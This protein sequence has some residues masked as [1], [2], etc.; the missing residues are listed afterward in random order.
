MRLSC[1]ITPLL[2]VVALIAAASTFAAPVRA[3]ADDCLPPLIFSPITPDNAAALAPVA[4]IGRGYHSAILWEDDGFRVRSEAGW[5]RYSLDLSGELCR[6]AAPDTLPVTPDSAPDAVWNRIP[7]DEQPFSRVLGVSPSGETWLIQVSIFASERSRTEV[8]NGDGSLRMTLLDAQAAAAA[9]SADESQ[10]ALLYPDGAITIMDASSGAGLAFRDGLPG[11]AA[12]M[13]ISPDG[14]AVMIGDA[15]GVR[16]WDA[17]TNMLIVS[18]PGS[19]GAVYLPDGASVAM[20][21]DEALAFFNISD[22]AEASSFPSEFQAFDTSIAISPDGRHIGIAHVLHGWSVYDAEAGLLFSD[23][24]LSE[25]YESDNDIALSDTHVAVAHVPAPDM[26]SLVV[27]RLADRALALE[28]LTAPITPLTFAP[29]GALLY[30][31]PDSTLEIY[32]LNA[33]AV[34]QTFAL[35]GTDVRDAQFSP[36]GRLLAGVGGGSLRVWDVASG[37]L[38][39]QAANEDGTLLFSPDG[40]YIVT[41][42]WHCY[43]CGSDESSQLSAARVWGIPAA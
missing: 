30:A 37:A 43:I 12:P 28:R 17:A 42:D 25:I 4:H 5:W 9:F 23:Y 15:Q 21:R 26:G 38:L 3:Q 14:A 10:F 35:D 2:I 24:F 8:V 40:A 7:A 18:L 33:N 27:Y 6:A 34:A 41:G 13:D 39:F 20:P 1:R 29:D 11:Y 16:L 36:D 22:G 32:D 19:Y 31:T